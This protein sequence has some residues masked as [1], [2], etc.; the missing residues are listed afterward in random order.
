[1]QILSKNTFIGAF[2]VLMVLFGMW[3]GL[4]SGQTDT[5]TTEVVSTG[6]EG[7][8]VNAL[9]SLRA[10]TLS[11]TIFSD[12]SFASLRDVGV[13][14]VQEPV[15]RRNPFA[16]IGNTA[17]TPVTTTTQNT[18]VVPPVPVGQSRGTR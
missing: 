7:E 18:T 10:V 15:G 5:L 13:E 9:I 14:I 12:P 6:A 2:L 17:P 1:M 3:W 4:P 8:V 11:G 16:T